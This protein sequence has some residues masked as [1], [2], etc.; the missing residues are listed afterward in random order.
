M[1]EVEGLQLYDL[2]LLKDW[3]KFRCPN[4]GDDRRVANN[5]ITNSTWKTFAEGLE[6]VSVIVP[7]AYSVDISRTIYC[8]L[9]FLTNG[10]VNPDFV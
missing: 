7:F 9:G 4:L 8:V 2:F 3:M 5:R 1:C 10:I 6:E